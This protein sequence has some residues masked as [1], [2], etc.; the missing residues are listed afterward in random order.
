VKWYTDWKVR[1]GWSLGKYS[2]RSTARREGGTERGRWVE[3]TR[4][5]QVTDGLRY[6]HVTFL[7]WTRKQKS[8]HMRRRVSFVNPSASYSTTP[9]QHT[10]TQVFSCL[11]TWTVTTE[12]RAR[13]TPWSS[14]VHVFRQE[15]TCVCP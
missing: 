3:K 7:P 1:V 6:D 8:F 12:W 13:H 2:G 11:K 14:L 9:L 4:G 10:H 5:H 15:N